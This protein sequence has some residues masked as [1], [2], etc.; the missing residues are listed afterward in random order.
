M[1]FR[2]YLKCA[3][4]LNY[5][6]KYLTYDTMDIVTIC[7]PTQTLY[8]VI[9]MHS[10]YVCPCHVLETPQLCQPESHEALS[11][12][13]EIAFFCR[14]PPWP[15]SDLAAAHSNP[16]PGPR[17][18]HSGPQLREKKRR[19]NRISVSKMKQNNTSAP[20]A[21]VHMP[22]N[23]NKRIHVISRGDAR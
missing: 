2:R 16:D 9:S 23:R 15:L 19:K 8:S 5:V 17:S 18:M 3:T 10:G 12:P 21:S 20:R 1:F 11:K 6:L 4:H 7:T 13:R 22:Y 14:K